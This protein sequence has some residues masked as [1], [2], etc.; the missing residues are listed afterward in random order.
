MPQVI[1]DALSLQELEFA[2]FFSPIGWSS[3][4]PEKPIRTTLWQA[5]YSNRSEPPLMKRLENELL[6]GWFV[7]TG[8]DDL[9]R[10]LSL[11]RRTPTGAWKATSLQSPTVQS[12]RSPR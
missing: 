6:F 9:L 5:F 8:V 11:F 10:T 2:A 1:N 4:A 3:I 7:D 12:R